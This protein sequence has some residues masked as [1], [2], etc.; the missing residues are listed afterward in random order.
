VVD[1][2]TNLGRSFLIRDCSVFVNLFD[3]NNS[4]TEHTPLLN[5]SQFQFVNGIAIA[6]QNPVYIKYPHIISL[7]RSNY[8]TG[9]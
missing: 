6:I 3:S 8:F 2:D 5:E 9:K 4:H 7:I 1:V